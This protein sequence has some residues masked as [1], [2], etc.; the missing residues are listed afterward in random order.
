MGNRTHYDFSE[1]RITSNPFDG[2]DYLPPY[3]F[4]RKYYSGTSTLLKTVTTDYTNTSSCPQSTTWAEPCTITTSYNDASSAPSSAVTMQYDVSSGISNPTQIQETN[5]LGNVVRT[6]V[7]TWE[8]GG[9]Y[10]DTAPPSGALSHILDRLESKTISDAVT[11]QSHTLGY[12]Y[13]GHANLHIVKVT[14]SDAASTTT[15]YGYNDYG[16]RIQAIDPKGNQTNYGYSNPFE[17]SA[18]SAVTDSAGVPSS[19]TNALGRTTVLSYYSCSGQMASSTDPNGAVSN[20]TY[21]TLGRSLSRSVQGSNN[22]LAAQESY[23]YK[24]TAPL[25]VTHTVA[26]YSTSQITTK[27]VLDGLGRLH[28]TQLMLDS[29]EA[30]YV[31]K[32]YDALGRVASVS[33]PYR[34]ISDPTYGVTLYNYDALARVTLQTQPDGSKLQWCYDGAASTGQSNCLPSKSSKSGVTWEDFSDE[35]GRH[36]Q[37]AHDALGRLVAVMELGKDDSSFS[38]ETDYTYSGL[39][40]L[41]TVS[42]QGASGEI[43]RARSFTYDSLSRLI[44]S[45]NAEN[46]TICYGIWSG[47]N[48]VYGY[49]LNG[50]LLNR[51]DARGIVTAYS[52]DALSRLISKSFSGET[53][54][55]G[56]PSAHPTLTSC[57]SYDAGFGAGSN[58]IGRLTGEWTQAG[59]CPASAQDIPPS[60]MSWKNGISYDAMG[61]LTDEIQCPVAPCL[62]PSPMHYS[63]DLAGNVTHQGNGLANSQSPQI[64]WTNSYDDA[65]RLK[66]IVSDWSDPGHPATLFRADTDI[67]ING[68]SHAPYGPFGLTAA[69]YGISETDGTVALAEQRDYDNRGRLITKNIFGSN[70]PTIITTATSV[71]ANPTTFNTASATTIVI[72]VNCNSACGLVDI[73]VDTVDLGN[74]TLDTNGSISVS[75]ASFP[76]SALSIGQHAVIAQYLG[77][78]THAPSSGQT[79]YTVTSSSQFLTLSMSNNAFTVGE[80]SRIQVHAACNSACGSVTLSVDGQTWRVWNLDSAGN[81]VLDS[82]FWEDIS[83]N[84][85]NVGQHVL[86]AH[87]SGNSTYPASDSDGYSYT[88][89]SVGTQQAVP[90]LTMSSI[91]FTSGDNSHIS[92]HHPCNSACGQIVLNIDGNFYRNLQLDGSGNAYVDTFWWWTP[93]FTVGNHTMTAQYL[94]NHTYAPADATPVS[95]TIQNIGTQQATVSLS[96][97]AA[98]GPG[99]ATPLVVQVDCNSACGVVQLTVDG[100][101]W[102]TWNLYANGTLSIDALHWPPPLLTPGSHTIKA[103]FY[104]NAT[105]APADSAPQTVTV[106]KFLTLSMSNNAFTAGEN[107]RIQVHA[108]CNSACGS[109]TLSVDGQTWRVWNLDSGGNLILDSWFWDDISPNFSNV[110]QHVL[111]AHFGGNSTYPASDSDGYSYTIQSVGTQQAVPSF[112]MSSISFTSGDNPHISLHHPCNSACGQIVLNIDGSFYRNLQLDS[113]GNAYIDTFWWWTPLF[114][115][116]N[117]TMTAQYLG[118]HTYAPADATPVSFAV[119]NIG[120]QQTTVSLSIP[121]AFGPGSATPLV[122]QVDCN[123]ACGVVQLTVDGNEWRAWNLYANGTLSIDA[124]HWPTP[125]LTPGNHTIKAHFYGN[126]TYAPADS[127]PQTVTVAQ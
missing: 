79:T 36:W 85:S 73:H 109:V 84:F 119:Q 52:Y 101:E 39:G 28:Q 118:N 19:I 22:V 66:Q 82:W 25:T 57:Y 56:T 113:S 43:P 59:S 4:S 75:S 124:L 44:T 125:L 90:S 31:D 111:V 112:T 87:F 94:G 27:Y 117:H 122:V 16:D 17:D 77:D 35:S 99:S 33:N 5:F 45:T 6:T 29:N 41:L 126:A 54:P 51:T 123:S 86:V 83:P 7:N 61:R 12:T 114:A 105:Y 93:L 98:F 120:T 11:G 65:S 76:I 71:A 48:C 13:D 89:Q 37:R 70:S 20:F 80:N 32:T 107:S 53:N 55:D 14:A 115:V 62:A 21:D 2:G 127:A 121:T 42:Q 18:C 67:N 9:I 34:N 8:H 26:K 10:A 91:S 64:G 24:D 88:I 68:V 15:Q 38:L 63:Y 106:A 108:A 110:G 49:D 95:F 50:N 72:N 23:S 103:H 100:N 60:A 47:S 102:R 92:I 1:G 3:E 30:D 74:Q 69:Q 46:K 104:G 78:S 97:P 58:S 116:G 96:I 81:L 40:N